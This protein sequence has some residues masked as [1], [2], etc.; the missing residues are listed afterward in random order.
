MVCEPFSGLLDERHVTRGSNKYREYTEEAVE[1]LRTI[2]EI[3]A[4]G[5]TLSGLPRRQA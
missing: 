1:H 3:Q 4:A 2:K 5:F